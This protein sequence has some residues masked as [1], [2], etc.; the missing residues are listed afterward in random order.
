M[1]IHTFSDAVSSRRGA[2]ADE[3]EDDDDDEGEVRVS[4]KV[5][6]GEE[7]EGAEKVLLLL[8]LFPILHLIQMAY[9]S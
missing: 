9:L 8:S 1:N 5:V 4:K 6:D 7:E 2:L 3:V